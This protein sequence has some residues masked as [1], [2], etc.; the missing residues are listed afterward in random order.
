M[1]QS[2]EKRIILFSF[3]ILSLTIL[4]NT[5]M[6]IAVFRKDYIQEM[7]LRSQSIGTALKGNIEKVLALGIDIKDVNG[8][9]DKCREVVQ[10]DP[11]I[12]YCVITGG[13]AKPLFASESSFT[14]FDFSQKGPPP[15]EANTKQLK[16]TTIKT[17]RGL[18]YNTVTPIRSFDGKTVALVNIGFPQDAIDQK[19]HAII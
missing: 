9:A 5:G 18:Y 12:A 4:A 11:E 15:S 10:S 17:V 16:T 8:L 1:K 7:L 19:V 2:L 13:D 6:D 14:T 3:V